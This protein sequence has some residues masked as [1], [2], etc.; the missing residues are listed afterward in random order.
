MIQLTMPS[1]MRHN[2]NGNATENQRGQAHHPKESIDDADAWDK[3]SVAA[4][5]V[6]RV[7][8]MP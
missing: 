3:F 7:E 2:H 1:A 8:D 5:T 6:D 4:L